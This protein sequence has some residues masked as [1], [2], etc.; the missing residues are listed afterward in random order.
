MIRAS[1]GKMYLL[2]IILENNIRFIENMPIG[3]DAA[4]LFEYF[5]YCKLVVFLDQSLYKYYELEGSVTKRYK[6]NFFS[7]QKKKHI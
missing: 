4:F 1:W 5:H 3:E 2:Q 7:I 6:E